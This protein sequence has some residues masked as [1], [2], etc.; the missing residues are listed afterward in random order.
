MTTALAAISLLIVRLVLLGWVGFSTWAF[1]VD[2]PAIYRTVKCEDAE[3]VYYKQY[4]ISRWEF[5]KSRF[6]K[7]HYWLLWVIYLASIALCLFW[8]FA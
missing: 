2:Y 7:W 1:L 5:H 6:K 8:W 4:R 3:G